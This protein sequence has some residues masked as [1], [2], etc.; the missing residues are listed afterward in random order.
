MIQ[1][2]RDAS[3]PIG[4]QLVEQL[5]FHL[6]T[7]RFQPGEQLPSTRALGDQLGISV[8][9]VRKAYQELEREGLLEARRGSGYTVLERTLAPAADRMER[10]AAIVHETLQKLVSL[11]LAEDEIEYLVGEQLAFLD[12]REGR[13]KVL[14]AAPYRELAEAA[15]E[16]LSAAVQERVEPVVLA[17]LGR[18]PEADVV[19]APHAHLREALSAVS[20]AD[21]VG[22]SVQLPSDAL[23]RVARLLPTQTLGLV[24]RYGD[25]IGPLMAEIRHQTGFAGQTLALAA[26]SDRGRLSDLLRQVDLLVF[27]PQARRRLRPLLDA[28]AHA[29]LTFELAPAVVE[30]VREA[31]R[32]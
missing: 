32:R 12:R 11:G 3:T 6:A 8:H 21:T 10:G 29:P 4:E 1:L 7:G 20:G 26:D 19:V 17:E 30:A 22:C 24:T 5:R 15:A 13:P 27:T 9:T 31:V 14:A 2:D 28:V 25:A 23:E 16:Q 18:H